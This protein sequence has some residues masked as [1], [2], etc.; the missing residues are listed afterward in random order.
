MKGGETLE[1]SFFISN[2]GLLS[3][4][5]NNE[6]NARSSKQIAQDDFVRRAKN[7][8]FGRELSS[9]ECDCRMS[10][11]KWTDTKM[12]P[13]KAHSGLLINRSLF[14]MSCTVKHPVLV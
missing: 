8:P 6:Q 4:C 11:R 5:R 12:Q 9:N 3:K 1:G 14:S 7:M 13:S 2:V 10:R